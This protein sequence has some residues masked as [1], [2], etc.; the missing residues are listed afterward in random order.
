MENRR[1]H[2][3]FGPGKLGLGLVTWATR[4]Q[5]MRVTLVTHSDRIESEEKNA[6][7]VRNKCYFIQGLTREKVFVDGLVGYGPANKFPTLREAIVDA[8][9]VLLTTSLRDNLKNIVEMLGELLLARH[10]ANVASNLYIL[11]AEN[12]RDSVWLQREIEKYFARSNPAINASDILRQVTFVPCVVDRVCTRVVVEDGEVVVTAFPT[13]RW[14]IQDPGGHTGVE[15]RAVLPPDDTIEYVA[16][17]K[18][19]RKIKLYLYNG[20]HLLLAIFAFIENIYLLPQFLGTENGERVLRL[21][22]HECERTLTHLDRAIPLKRIKEDIKKNEMRFRS[23][24]DP[25]ARILSRLSG[26]RNLPKFL[27]DFHHKVGL[28]ALSYLRTGGR[29]LNVIPLALFSLIERIQEHD[30]PAAKRRKRQR[31]SRQ[32]V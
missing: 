4:K 3:H 31:D 29:D 6:L 26:D 14:L 24:P 25:V 17:I 28:P 27:E 10:Q 23:D 7:L 16:D 20:P 30:Y 18:L 1:R 13:A 12:T 11:A 19:E 5:G 2:L 21:V 9:T 32:Q 8:E 15:L 22:F